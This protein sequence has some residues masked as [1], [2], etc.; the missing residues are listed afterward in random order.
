MP[1]PTLRGSSRCRK[2]P[3]THGAHFQ[4]NRDKSKGKQRENTRAHVLKCK[5]LPRDTTRARHGWR[6]GGGGAQLLGLGLVLEAKV[7]AGPGGGAR[8]RLPPMPR[9][10]SGNCS[11]PTPTRAFVAQLVVGCACLTVLAP[12]PPGPCS[13]GPGYRP[14]TAGPTGSRRGGP[15]LPALK[16]PASR[17]LSPGGPSGVR[18]AGQTPLY[19]EEAVNRHRYHQLCQPVGRRPPTRTGAC[20]APPPHRAPRRARAGPHPSSTPPC[21]SCTPRLSSSPVSA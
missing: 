16:L 17:G 10:G 4:T 1:T 15:S 9:P 5:E 13:P 8:W 11:A 2:D 19:A 20:A 7:C 12:S 3:F 21:G 6:R 18:P 14:V